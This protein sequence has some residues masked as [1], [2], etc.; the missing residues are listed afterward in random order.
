MNHSTNH[1][2][3]NQYVKSLFVREDRLSVKI[4][5]VPVK[6]VHYFAAI[7][8]VK[9]YLHENG[10][11]YG[12]LDHA[13]ELIFDQRLFDQEIEVARGVSPIHGKAGAFIRSKKDAK[14]TTQDPNIVAENEILFEVMEATQGISGTDVYGDIIPAKSGDMPKAA[15]GRGVKREGTQIIAAADGYLKATEESISILNEYIISGNVDRYIGNIEFPGDVRVQGDVN[16]GYI[17]AAGGNVI[18]EG[19][20]ENSSIISGGNITIANGLFG[21]NRST[22]SAKGDIHIKFIEHASS[23]E[24]GQ[25]VYTNII[26]NSKVYAMDQVVVSGSD[27]MIIGGR[28]VAHNMITCNEAGFKSFVRTELIVGLTNERLEELERTQQVYEL[29]ANET[30]EIRKNIAYLEEKHNNVND[31]K[32]AEIKQDL[33]E[34]TMKRSYNLG[35]LAELKERMEKLRSQVN[36][37]ARILVNKTIYPLTICNV[38]NHVFEVTQ[39]ME[40]RCIFSDENE[41]YVID[42]DDQIHIGK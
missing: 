39:H 35:I 33:N 23:V 5:V 29:L 40:H 41:V 13:I 3:A 18:V 26:L 27:G 28:T 16:E 12:I 25:S 7:Q 6:K 14:N 34:F 19:L 36:T 4:V 11:V 42:Y 21:G 38:N 37:V 1:A 22:I 15:L 32:K 9:A 31:E 8:A 2:N 10:I 24:A 17:I 30:E 20:V